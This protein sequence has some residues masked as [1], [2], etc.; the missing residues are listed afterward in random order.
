MAKFKR[1]N[2]LYIAK[3]NLTGLKGAEVELRKELP[4]H[5]DRDRLVK[6]QI[7]VNQDKAVIRIGVSVM[8]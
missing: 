1:K 5:A 3:G 2:F 7:A 8:L 6:I 4:L